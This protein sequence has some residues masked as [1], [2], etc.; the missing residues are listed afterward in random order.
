[1]DTDRF[2]HLIPVLPQDEIG[3]DVTPERHGEAADGA[4]GVG[5]GVD[6]GL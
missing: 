5:M 4:A 6:V 1:V 3:D 2:G